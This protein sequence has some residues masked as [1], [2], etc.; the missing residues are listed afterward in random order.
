MNITKQ[1]SDLNA[2]ALKGDMIAA[3]TQFFADDSKTI[4]HTGVSLH[5]KKEHLEKMEGFL[6]GIA[7]VK[8]HYAAPCGCRRRCKF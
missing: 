5:N 2:L 8:R 7:K 4:D 6:G 3:V 1:N